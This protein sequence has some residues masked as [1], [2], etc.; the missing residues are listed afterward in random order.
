MIQLALGL[1]EIRA[2]L[3]RFW[4][5]H[6]NIVCFSCLRIAHALERYYGFD[7]NDILGVRCVVAYREVQ[8]N[9][10]NQI[11]GFEHRT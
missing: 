7:W 10:A 9:M 3:N 4:Q 8:A 6:R 1:Q 11:R 2:H 5:K